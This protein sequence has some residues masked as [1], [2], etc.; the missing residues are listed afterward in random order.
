MDKG[1]GWF[2]VILGLF[3]ILFVAFMQISTTWTA[4]S[5]AGKEVFNSDVDY[6]AFKVVLAQK[7][8]EINQML[9]LNTSPTI[10][11]FGVSVPNGSYFPYGEK[12]SKGIPL[13]SLIGLPILG[14]ITVIMGVDIIAHSK[15]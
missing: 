7:S 2:V 13:W 6:T 3:V 10:V 1:T 9:V 11:K 15:E 14:I 4:D 5:Y 8:V 12:E